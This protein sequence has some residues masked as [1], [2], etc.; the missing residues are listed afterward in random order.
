MRGISAAQIL[1]VPVCCVSCMGG[2]RRGWHYYNRA[3][4]ASTFEESMLPEAASCSRATRSTASSAAMLI[5]LSFSEA[6]QGAV[7]G[8][9]GENIDIS[10]LI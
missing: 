7:V 1:Y 2:L 9:T 5:S 3:S 6:K 8:I 10:E 4:G